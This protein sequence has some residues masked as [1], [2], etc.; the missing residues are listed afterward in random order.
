MNA[1]QLLIAATVAIAAG[2]AFADT[3]SPSEN[4]APTKTRAEVRAELV[5]ANAEGLTLMGRPDAGYPFQQ[6]VKSTLT[7]AEVQ[8]ELAKARAQG[9]TL[10]DRTD[11]DYPLQQQ[12]KST[13]TRAQ[14][15]AELAADRQHSLIS[16]SDS[17]Y[18][19][20]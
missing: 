7:R 6:Q 5:K 2:S 11:A 8:A 14:V 20:P 10:M 15:Q 19:R 12:A 9:L 16:Y 17:Q 18:P 4:A 3:V 1:K 13:V